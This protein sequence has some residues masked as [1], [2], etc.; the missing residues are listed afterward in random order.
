MLPRFGSSP[1]RRAAAVALA[2]LALVLVQVLALAGPAPLALALTPAEIEAGNQAARRVQ[3]EQEE[4]RLQQLR[5][6][7]QRRGAE[8]SVPTPEAKAPSL[9]KGG[10]CRE[11]TR[12]VLTGA[13]LLSPAE[14]AALT[15]PYEGRCLYAEDIEHLLGDILKAYMDRGY[16]A[17]RPYVRAQDL[18]GGRLEILIVEGRVERLDLKGSKGWFAPNLSTAFPGMQGRPLNLRDIEQGL[19]QINRLGSNQASMEIE[20]GEEPGASVVVIKNE[21]SFPL[22]LS[23]GMDNLGGLSTGRDQGSYT[24]SL[25]S[26]LGLGD[27]LTYTRRT[28]LFERD[29]YRDSRSDSLFY[30]VPLGYWTF[31]AS[32]SFSD[33][34]SPVTTTTTTLVA[35]GSSESFR[36]EASYVAY[37]DQD[38]KLTLLAAINR[39][40]TRNYL[41]DSFLEV[42]SRNLTIADADATWQKQLSWASAN[43]GLGFSQGLRELNAKADP[44]GT[45]VVSPHAQGAKVRYSGGLAVPFSLLGQN[46]TFTS[47]ATG[48]FAL[49]PLYGSEQITLGSFYTVRG[50]NRNSL[51]ADRGWYVRNEL[52]TA[53]PALPFIDVTPRPFVAF[54]G[55]RVE[56]FKTIRDAN[57]TGVAGGLRVSGGHV[58]GELS[59][60]K[61]LSTP[62]SLPHEPAQFS[63]TLTA[64]F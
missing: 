19:D 34:H 56:G 40:G 20:P 49:E 21:Q 17:V 64:S 45:G 38:Q 8:T 58:S 59:V 12:I 47:Q 41:A 37:R 25:D 33:Y 36:A 9:P 30:S 24:V 39:K 54:D 16:V 60:A 10:V 43:L 44:E 3:Q 29:Q 42:S 6:D 4:R 23:A 22:K 63:A 7:A 28:T 46:V 15:A 55:G 14:Q 57:L 50:F 2:A 26:P 53:L 52:S 11:I 48:Q 1:D 13:S 27:Y 18:S 51:S 5:E 61:S 62:V 31:Q 35:R 32:Y